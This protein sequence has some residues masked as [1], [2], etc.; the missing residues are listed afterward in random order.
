MIPQPVEL[1]KQ[2]LRIADVYVEWI[3]ERERLRNTVEKGS[4][5][6][7]YMKQLMVQKMKQQESMFKSHS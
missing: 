5:F 4:G 2:K 7:A 1:G 6:Q 3:E